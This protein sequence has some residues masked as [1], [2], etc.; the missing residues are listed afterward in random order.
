MLFGQQL[1]FATEEATLILLVPRF[2][3]ITPKKGDFQYALQ[4]TGERKN[5]D[6][7]L[8]SRLVF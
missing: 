4:R 2:G 6:K 5:S 1:L 3:Y 7:T 8:K